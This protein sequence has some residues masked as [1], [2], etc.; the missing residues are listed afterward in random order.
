MSNQFVFNAPLNNVSFGQTSIAI[1]RE[2]YKRGLMPQIM[3]IGQVDLSSQKPDQGF[4]VW[5][6]NCINSAPLKHS[7]K[8]TAYKLWHVMQSNETYSSQ[9][10]RLITFQ[11]TGQLT[12]VEVN[13]LKQQDKVYVTNRYA[14]TFFRMYGIET[15]YM[16][17][18]FDSH[19]FTSLPVRPKIEGV[20]SWLLTSKAEHRKHTYRQLGLWAKKYGNRKEHRLNAAMTNPFLKPEDQQALISRALDGKAYW[21]INWLDFAPTNAEYSCTLQSSDIILC[22]SGSEGFGLPEFHATALGAWP[23]ALKA[24][25]Y[26]DFF[27]DE[28][29]VL[30]NPNGMVPV[31]DGIFFREDSPINKGNIFSFA[32]EDWYA[33]CE[34]AERRVKLLGVNKKGLELK[35]WTYAKAVDILMEK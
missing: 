29:A 6:Q 32:D 33:A 20:T 2:M 12:P 1:L 13:L 11:E 3:P 4:N 23:V 18:G 7:R 31:Y 16:P 24:H 15:T 27:T 19:N 8:N 14:Q 17:L 21:N 9:D 22:C 35:N 25:S 10:S 5:L 26:L 28:N 30:V 34:E